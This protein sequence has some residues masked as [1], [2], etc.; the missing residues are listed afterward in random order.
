M[1][2]KGF[3]FPAWYFTQ[4]RENDSKMNAGLSMKYRIV[5]YVLNQMSTIW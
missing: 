2:Q 3:M 5:Q 4:L 1:D